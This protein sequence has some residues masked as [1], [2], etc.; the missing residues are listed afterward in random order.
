MIRQMIDFVCFTINKGTTIHFQKKLSEH[1]FMLCNVIHTKRSQNNYF[2]LS[3]N[4]LL[5]GFSSHSRKNYPKLK[6]NYGLTIFCRFTNSI[7]NLCPIN[8]CPSE[9]K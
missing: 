4:P 6:G 7:A 8:L 9:L 3:F 1:E 2:Q 5:P